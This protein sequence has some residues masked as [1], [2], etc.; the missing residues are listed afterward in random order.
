MAKLSLS[1]A[2]RKLSTVNKKYVDNKTSEIINDTNSS[3]NT[4]YSSEKIDS[5]IGDIQRIL[6]EIVGTNTTGN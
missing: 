3:V 5:M 1:E 4:T 2:I 6:D